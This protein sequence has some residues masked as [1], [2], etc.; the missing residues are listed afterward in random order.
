[1]VDWNESGNVIRHIFWFW[2]DFHWQCSCFK[3]LITLHFRRWQTSLLVRPK[4]SSFCLRS[5]H[6]TKSFACFRN[7]WK[8]WRNGSMWVLYQSHHH[9]ISYCFTLEQG[10]QWWNQSHLQCLA[11]IK[12]WCVLH[13]HWPLDWG[14]NPQGVGQTGGTFRLYSDEHCS[15]WSS[16]GPSIIP[17]LQSAG[18]CSQG[19]CIH[20]N[21]NAPECIIPSF[22]SATSHATMQ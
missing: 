5:R 12:F 13:C 3:H 9:H 11:G 20:I 17:S 19:T 16:T 15:Q 10:C 6:E 21:D 8:P 7:R 14:G 2:T 22:R 4:V 1:M 18:H